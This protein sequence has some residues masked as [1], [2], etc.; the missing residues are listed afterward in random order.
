MK[1]SKRSEKVPKWFPKK[2]RK[3]PLN[4]TISKKPKSEKDRESFLEGFW[5]FNFAVKENGKFKTCFQ[6]DK[7]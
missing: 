1:N 5:I 6:G 7:T 2:V 4:H 3:N